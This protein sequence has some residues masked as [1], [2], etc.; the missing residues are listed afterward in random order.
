MQSYNGQSEKKT[1]RPQMFH[2]VYLFQFVH[3]RKS[4]RKH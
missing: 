1:V 4:K 2:V 3:F